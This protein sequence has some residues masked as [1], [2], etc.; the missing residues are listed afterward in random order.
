MTLGELID[1]LKAA[2]QGVVCKMGFSRPHSYRGYYD[3]L[4]FEPTDNAKVSEMLKCAE[5]SL[6]KEF[7]GYKGGEYT[8]DKHTDVWLAHYGNSGE[9]LSPLAIAFML[10]GGEPPKKVCPACDGVGKVPFSYR[11]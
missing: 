3:Q 7:T 5:E 11:S 9:M 6:G 8:M 10:G 2:D 4:A 1:T